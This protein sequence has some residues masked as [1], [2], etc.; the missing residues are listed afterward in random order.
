[1]RAPMAT[2]AVGMAPAAVDV[3]VDVV[4]EAAAL[5]LALAR[6]LL[7]DSR[8]EWREEET[9]PFAVWISELILAIL[10]L[11]LAAAAVLICSDVEA[12]VLVAVEAAFPVLLSTALEMEPRTLST[13]LEALPAAED[14][15][16]LAEETMPL[17]LSRAEDAASLIEE[18][19]L[20]CARRITS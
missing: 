1:M 8:A 17:A 15:A 6:A 20:C 18:T 3:L 12:S 10:L 19:S 5:A 4:A 9:A 13:T 14:A 7:A 2:A 11:M 16:P